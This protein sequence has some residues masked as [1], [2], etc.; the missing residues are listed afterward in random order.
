MRG[1]NPTKSTRNRVF[2]IVLG[3]ATVGALPL[4]SGQAIAQG[5]AILEEIIVTAQRREENLQEVPIS[6]TALSG[7]RLESLFEGGADILA[8]AARVPS[9][10][11]ESSNGRLAPRFYMRGLGNTD[12]DLAASQS[13][14]IL[15]DEVVQ[16]N[17]VLKSFPL[18]DIARVEVLRGP[19]GTLFGRNTPAGIVKFDTRKPTEEFEGY[20]L[21]TVGTAG[22][23]NVE[24]ALGGSLNAART[25]QGRISVLSQNRGD[26]IDNGYTGEKDA[27]GGWNE[28]AW[29][30]QLLWQPT[31]SFSALLNYHGRDLRN[32]TASIF[33]AN[34]VTQGNNALNN[35]FRRNRVYFNEGDN[36]PQ[37]AR[38]DGG[39]LKLDFDFG[40]DMTLTSISAYETVHNRSLGDI[41]GG[42]P[43]GPGFIPFQSV[44]Q[45]GLDDLDQFTQEFR[46]ASEVRDGLFWQAGV[47]YF[48][49]K[50]DVTTNPF[51]VPP[52]TLH[53]SN[54]AWALFGQVSYDIT[55]RF[56]LT[57]GVRY[58]DDQKKLKGVATNF[59]VANVSLDDTNVSW[60]LSGM[61][62]VSNSVNVYGRVATGF[63]APS[64]QGRDVAF[65]APPSTAKSETITSGEVGFKSTIADDRIRVNGAV[66]YYQ[67][68]DQQFTAI[69]GAS[70]SVQLVNAD[71]GIGSG[72][73][74]D[75]EMLFTDN[76][77]AT[78]GL[79]YNRTEIKDPNLRVAICGSGQCTVTDPLDS[80]GFAIVNGNAFPQA[81][82]LILNL[83]LRYSQPVDG[84][85]LFFVTDWSRQ[86]DTQFFLYESNEFHSGDIYEG[87]VRAGFT[88]DDDRW[89]IA[90]F[91]RNITDEENLKGGIDF[92][93]N[94]GFV[95]DRRI[96][97]ATFRI[98]FGTF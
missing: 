53:H 67:I 50:F 3:I 86:S 74:L 4:S 47:F 48:D 57:G 96:W 92:N 7:E 70:N 71:K 61:F 84:G 81:P 13:V 78:V 31:D 65:F 28:L 22:T 45:D 79:S 33:Q 56:N 11:A 29:R 12:F 72:F 17:V 8:L 75:T 44:T 90:V 69:G 26:W 27:M 10:Y 20:A 58:T 88:A 49:S 82:D 77:M 30:T 21:G 18:F 35:N 98:N 2:G 52:T 73:D 41:D 5:N 15:F 63:R 24:G 43:S 59:P 91:G 95:N 68:K 16:E 64:I 19:Q 80:N 38:G 89:E 85:E 42:N 83:T 97:G 93:N 37:D 6:V 40:N 32:G 23:M 55:D 54:T 36:N 60:D 66:Y 25:L 9:L 62:A 94:T 46:L 39:S 87:G 51:F 1:Y 76:F 34:I 14:S